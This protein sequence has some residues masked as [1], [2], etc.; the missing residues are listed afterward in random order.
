MSET[1]V[2]MIEKNF[3]FYHSNFN[4]PR[5]FMFLR[6]SQMSEILVR[7]SEFIAE[8]AVLESVSEFHLRMSE[9]EDGI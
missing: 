2:R 3:A 1:E 4:L 6:A 9:I 7:M 8:P 5:P